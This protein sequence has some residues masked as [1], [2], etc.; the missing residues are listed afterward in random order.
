MDITKSSFDKRQ[1]VQKNYDLIAEQYSN[2]FGTYIE[3]LDVY[4][5]F[6]QHLVENAKILDLGAGSGRTYSYFNKQNYEYTG[7]D[8]SK[9]MKDCAYDLH[10]KF[11]YIVDDMVN[12]KRYFSNN[13]LDAVFAVYSLFHLPKNDFNNLFS[14]VYDILKVNGIFLFTYQIG[15]G[16]EMANEPYLNEKGKNS[17]YMC[18]HTKEEVN[19]LLH[20][21]S[22]T[23]LFKKQKIEMSPSAINNN[24]VTTVFILAKK[25][26]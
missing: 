14:D 15:Q 7:L 11:P 12:V 10:G 3:D 18:Y 23:E 20:S 17:L 16:E 26:K 13:S 5:K 19:D 9:K 4:E 2:E 25:I 21:F 1:S 22:Y 24:S 6:E 8:F